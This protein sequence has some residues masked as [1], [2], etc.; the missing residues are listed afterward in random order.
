MIWTVA[1]IAG[2]TL[3][4][5][6]L[7]A[8]IFSTVLVPYG[9]PGLLAKRLYRTVWPAWRSFSSFWGRKRRRLLSLGG[10]LLMVLTVLLWVLLLVLG[11]A[12]IYFP[13]AEELL[14]NDTDLPSRIMAATYTSAYAATT[15]GIG[16]IY[17]TSGW[18]R[19]LLTLEAAIGFALFTAAVSY[20]LAVGGA[21]LSA[22]SAALHISHFMGI[23]L[24]SEEGTTV[25]I[26]RSHDAQTERQIIDWISTTTTTLATVIRSDQQYPLGQY[27]HIPSDSSAL[28][29]AMAQL[30]ELTTTCR[31]MLDPETYPGP[32]GAPS[33]L[34]CYSLL[35]N[36][37]HTSVS[38]NK[39]GSDTEPITGL[40]EMRDESFD[41]SYARLRKAG[42][43]LRNKADAR[44][45]YTL[46]REQWDS[47]LIAISEYL[48]YPTR[49]DT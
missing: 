5:C 14:L 3:L 6:L 17:A 38:D 44:R 41:K 40:D 18:I 16:D 47:D 32:S 7:L 19:M 23:G 31:S 30:L 29:T 42:V 21:V 10:P 15:L 20:I 1:S 46:L 4:L 26:A 11:F 43:T 48:G 36:Y 34:A 49:R 24:D 13:F 45:R 8:D 9:G 28:P 33:V 37:L 2:G 12:L 22:T 25:T 27:F 35:Q 39:I